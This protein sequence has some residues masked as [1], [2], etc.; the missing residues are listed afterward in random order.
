[1]NRSTRLGCAAALI[2]IVPLI[3][4][5]GMSQFVIAED[6]F[7]NGAF[8]MAR[9]YEGPYQWSGL[10]AAN[11]SDLRGVADDAGFDAYDGAGFILAG[12]GARGEPAQPTMSIRRRI[13]AFTS[14]NIYRWIDTYTN[15]GEETITVNVAFWTN[16]GS[17][18]GEFVAAQDA[19]RFV[20]FEDD[21]LTGTTPTDPVVAMM[22]GNN[23][24]AAANISLVRF[25]DQDENFWL[26]DIWRFFTLVLEPGES[27]SLMFADFLAYAPDEFG[28]QGSPED[29]DL[30]LARSAELIAD[31]TDLFSDLERGLADSIVNWTIPAPGTA[32]IL[33]L[34]A[35]TMRRRRAG[36]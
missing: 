20:S 1:M 23:D 16:L 24:W 12:T 5:A 2:G 18:G 8:D 7:I 28:F 14:M 3:A 27:R 35:I 10:N 17:D 33:G 26:D 29:V 34:S 31:P 4:S 9:S 32:C 15:T 36:G 6:I 19:F 30:A 11:P 13:D 25:D 22:H 21:F